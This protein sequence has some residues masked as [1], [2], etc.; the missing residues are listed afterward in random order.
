[1]SDQVGNQNVGFLTTRLN[2]DFIQTPPNGDKNKQDEYGLDLLCSVGKSN[3][4][5]MSDKTWMIQMNMLQYV[6]AGRAHYSA[7]FVMSLLK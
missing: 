5:E 2:S 1:M 3:G 4:E 7:D 6:F